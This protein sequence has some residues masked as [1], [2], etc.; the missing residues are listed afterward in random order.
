VQLYTNVE[1]V[2]V[3]APRRTVVVRNPEGVEERI[4]LDDQVAGFD[5]IKAGDRV[6]RSSG[7]AARSRRRWP[8][9]RT[10]PDDPSSPTTYARSRGVTRSTGTVGA[11]P[12]PSVVKPEEP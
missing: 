3:D 1:V 4:E 7:R 11:E 12:R 2:A 6:I 9:R 10:L 8:G 5:D